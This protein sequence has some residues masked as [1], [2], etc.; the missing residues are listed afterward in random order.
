MLADFEGEGAREWLGKLVRGEV[1]GNW[2]S[3]VI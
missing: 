1:D 3:S 2:S